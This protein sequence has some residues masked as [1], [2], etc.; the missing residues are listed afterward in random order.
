M[1]ESINNNRK[2]PEL[3]YKESINISTLHNY[4][5]RKLS[6]EH[7]KKLSEANRGK[8]FSEKTLQKFKARKFTDS[9]RKKMSESHTGKILSEE[10]KRKISESVKKVAHKRKIKCRTTGEIF[11]SI[12]EA[13]EYYNIS[14][15]SL[16]NNL[17]GRSQS[18]GKLHGEKLEWAYY[19]E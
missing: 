16:K 1:K 2:K 17:A 19:K 8:K 15:G 6:E 12:V 13:S 7:R 11:D 4:S 10:H 5:G 18:A 14:L 3:E 9:T